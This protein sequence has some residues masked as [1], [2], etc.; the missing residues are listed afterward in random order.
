MR[1]LA[2]TLAQ[3]TQS[4][5][6]IGQPS[7]ALHELTLLNDSRRITEGAP[8]GQP[9]T[10]VAA[11]INVAIAGLYVNT[12]AD[13]LQKHTWQE[14]QL[15]ALQEQLA[16]INLAPF[17][18]QAFESEPAATCRMMETADLKKTTF[19]LSGSA[20]KRSIR[21]LFTDLK[22][23]QYDL[24]P[25]GWVYQNMVLTARLQHLLVDG[26]DLA[27]NLILPQ[28]FKD[29]AQQT[30]AAVSGTAK[31]FNFLA[32]IFIPNFIKATQT[33]ARNQTLVNEAQIAC[34]LE[35]YHLAHG[36]YPETLD[37]LM[38]QLIERLPHD[39]IGGQPLLYHRTGDG[40]F[41]LYSIG[42][43]EADDGGQVVFAKDGSID[44]EHGDW[45]W[46][47]PAK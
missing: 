7:H 42:W 26:F 27:N 47:Y 17:I 15:V 29:L 23:Y 12:I 22:S 25:H 31:P 3:R 36:E 28:K 16:G 20:G 38:P 39:L 32:A 45:V 41:L 9:M 19:V 40:K 5:L 24:V 18:F 33:L 30:D 11:M 1:K 37:A 2:Q 14:P 35:R 43:N 8:T 4:Y 10:L 13:G 46:Q 21:Q 44:R 6:L 34:A